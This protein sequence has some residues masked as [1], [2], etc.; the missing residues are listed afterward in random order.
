[1][2]KWRLLQAFA[3]RKPIVI[4]KDGGDRGITRLAVINAIEHED[5]SGHNFNVHGLC[6]KTGQKISVFVKTID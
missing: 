3:E 1:M 2:T 6:E 5:G 4:R